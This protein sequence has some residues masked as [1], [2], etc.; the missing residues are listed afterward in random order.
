MQGREAMG[1]TF[2]WTDFI[3][4]SFPFGIV[5]VWCS[6][7]E[8]Y[9]FVRFAHIWGIHVPINILRSI[10]G[11]RFIVWLSKSDIVI[12]LTHA[13]IGF[14]LVYYF[15]SF[16]AAIATL[17]SIVIGVVIRLSFEWIQRMM[18]KWI[19]SLQPQE[20]KNHQEK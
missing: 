11:N 7:M 4:H 13:G 17:G 6:C 5:A 3:G 10:L 20:Y 1:R 16:H 15:L 9:P 19:L 18:E 2:G 14:H 8:Q 12:Y